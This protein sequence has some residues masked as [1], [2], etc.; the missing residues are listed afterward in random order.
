MAEATRA[1]EGTALWLL[2][3]LEP[4]LARRAAAAAAW[5]RDQAEARRTVTVVH[6][7]DADGVTSG[8]IASATLDRA[9]VAH[10]RLPVKSLDDLNVELIRAGQPEALWFCDLGSTAY[11]HFP[12]TPRLVCDH[13]Q[14][15]RDGSEESFAHLNP[16]LDGLDGGSISGAG[17]AFLAALATDRA[18]LDL[19]PLALVGATADL[20]DGRSGPQ[21]RRPGFSGTNALLLQAGVAAGLLERR[22]DLAW[23]GP[24]S[25]PLGKY[26]SLGREPA[27]PGV[28]GERGD[29]AAMAFARACG[30]ATDAP[31]HDQPEPVRQAIRSALVDRLLD[32]GLG[33]AVPSLW[34]TVVTIPGEP[35]GPTRELQEYGTFLNGTAR[36]GKA[37]VGIAVARGD[38][39]AAYQEAMGLLDGHRKHLVGALAAFTDC[40]VTQAV[41]IQWVHLGDRVLDT[42]VGTVAGMALASLGLPRDK[43][44][45]AFAHTPDGRT[46][47]STRAPHELGGRIDLAVAVREAAAAVG[48]QGGGHPGAAGATVGRGDEARFLAELDGRVAAQLHGPRTQPILAAAKP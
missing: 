44:L 46:K 12:Q 47:V 48:G 23:Y 43:P 20:Q 22:E 26:L 14:L 27:V 33:A 25:R 24:A 42:V 13:H 1:P 11:M 41:A 31:W 3:Q 15:V 39:D 38:R 35:P 32:C 5:V 36:Y 30:A 34:R 7:I 10:R 6:H 29:S 18:N 4:A 45:V 16:I 2:G 9:G 37:D 21:G 28:T 40:P 19:L 17:C 8:A